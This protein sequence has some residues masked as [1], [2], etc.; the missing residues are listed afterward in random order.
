MTT[1]RNTIS[2]RTGVNTFIRLFYFFYSGAHDF[3]LQAAQDQAK[4]K[5]LL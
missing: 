2:Q 1:S 4:T 5:V 3:Q